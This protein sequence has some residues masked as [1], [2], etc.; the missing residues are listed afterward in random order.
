MTDKYYPIDAFYSFK[1]D[2]LYCIVKQVSADGKN[3]KI[4]KSNPKPN[5]TVRLAPFTKKIQY[6]L[7]IEETVTLELKYKHYYSLKKQL[8]R[9]YQ[10]K[11]IDKTF[12]TEK[13]PSLIKLEQE[14]YDDYK[15][16]TQFLQK[17][18]FSYDSGYV[19]SI[20]VSIWDIEVHFNDQGFPHA[21]EANFP[22]NAISKYNKNNNSADFYCL[23]N[24][25]AHKDP[26]I[27]LTKIREKFETNFPKIDKFNIYLFSTEEELIIS[28]LTDLKI[29]DVLVGWN[30]IGFDTLYMYTRCQ[31]LGLSRYFVASFGEMFTILNVVDSKQGAMVDTYY[32]TK[33]LSIDYIT[34]IKFFS[35][36][37]YSSY[38]LDFIA[39]AI[40]KDDESNTINAKVKIVNL[41]TEYLND[42]PNF[43]LYNLNDVI[44]NK[45]IDDKLQF[46][47]LL[48][49]LK[50]LTRGFTASLMSINNIL[51]SYISVKAKE[52]NLV[53]IS[54][55]KTGAFYKYKIWSI[56]R[57]VNNLTDDRIAMVNNLRKENKGFSIYAETDSLREE[58]S[59]TIDNMY[60]DENE[61]PENTELNKLQIPFIWNFD[62][63]SGAYVKVPKKGVYLNS[64]DFD[65]SLPPYEVIYIKRNWVIEKIQ[66][67]EYIFQEGDYCLSWDKNNNVCWSKIYGKV[68]HSWDGRLVNIRTMSG[69]E[70]HTT[71]NHSLFGIKREDFLNKN[72]NIIHAGKLVVGDYIVCID[73]IDNIEMVS[74]CNIVLEEIV[75]IYN[76]YYEGIVYDLS[77]D[78]TER[79]IAGSGIG[80][81]N[82]SM[83]PTSI[84]TTNNSPETWVYL[85]PENIALKYIYERENLI[86][87][88]KDHPFKMS[89]FDVRE[90]CFRTLYGDEII[91]FFTKMYDSE[92]VLTELGT[93]FIPSHL[94]EGFFRKL[95]SDPIAKRKVTKKKMN[96]LIKEK[97]LSKDHPDIINL[98]V[99]QLVY[100][101]ISNSCYG[102]MGS[103]TSRIFSIVLAATITISS[104][105]L[106]RF[107]ALQCNDI[108]ENLKENEDFK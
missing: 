53:C 102:Y 26:D 103:T 40:L 99:T 56:Y 28:F 21:H 42:L 54:K 16:E 87:Y 32:T 50:Q 10:N 82:T 48:F 83:Y 85:I 6:F 24:K 22:I 43:A 60:A 4:V 29:V 70:L 62:K 12:I 57:M 76:Y 58:D 27:L 69:K 89:V 14:I 106:I 39:Q 101:L 92:L 100:K 17:D 63:F 31:K 37:K 8:E 2:K 49:T 74:T 79:F 19:D 95:I 96:S 45:R 44:L 65:A 59:E 93:V 86:K 97:S 75:N 98:N 23:L 38:S 9:I 90:D 41:N 30:S 47:N 18:I 33:I 7:P 3:K 81:H 64:V 67:G 108:M 25:V 72:Y 104:Q 20:N 15:A 107:V 78:V 34:Y 73:N 71:Y 88:I 66:I 91:T 52:N 68:E 94:Q 13:F 77:V 84:Y 105:F 61:I 1:E 5:I 46:I 36:K 11:S 55:I 51:D 35:V 80:A